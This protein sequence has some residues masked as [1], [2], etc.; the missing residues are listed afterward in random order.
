[1]QNK[2]RTTIWISP[3]FLK[4]L[5]QMS[6]RA[7]CRSRSEFIEKALRFYNGYLK[8][9]EGNQYLPIALSSAMNGII[10]TSEDRIA[11][12]LYKNTGELSMLM[13]ILAATAEID[14]ETLKKLRKKC[15]KEVNG[16]RGQIQFEDAYRF[17][18]S[19]FKIVWISEKICGG[20][21][22]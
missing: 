17:Q 16:T 12:V 21:W 9:I 22:C 7:N 14:E 20:V 6:E 4:Q 15:A 2:Q 8:S 10:H 18:K 11:K 3:D 19:Q 1:M 5:D 13:N